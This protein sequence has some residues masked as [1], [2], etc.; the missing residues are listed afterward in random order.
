MGMVNY[1]LGGMHTYRT[2]EC[3]LAFAHVIVLTETATKP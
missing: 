1:G 2:T 3:P